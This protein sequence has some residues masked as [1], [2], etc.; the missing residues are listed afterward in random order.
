G[1]GQVQEPRGGLEGPRRRGGVEEDDSGLLLCC[2]L[3]EVGQHS[4]VSRG[5]GFHNE[6]FAALGVPR[7]VGE[8]LVQVIDA[9]AVYAKGVVRQVVCGGC[10][11][12]DVPIGVVRGGGHSAECG[13]ELAPGWAVTTA[14]VNG[15]SV[16]LAIAA[17]VRSSGEP[18]PM[19]SGS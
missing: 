13:G 10:A 18:A 19:A 6:D 17:W 1:V 4:G 2:V 11:P 5:C 8:A 14:R 12:Q 16:V 3:G 7:V 15:S 9:G